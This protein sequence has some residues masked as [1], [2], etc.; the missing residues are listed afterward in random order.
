METVS[1]IQYRF[2]QS[3]P[4]VICLKILKI[5][6]LSIQNSIYP[7]VELN[8]FSNFETIGSPIKGLDGNIS[9]LTLEEVQSEYDGHSSFEKYSSSNFMLPLQR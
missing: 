5:S 8:G 4:I 9:P 2:L 6:S 1:Q 7:V 3:K